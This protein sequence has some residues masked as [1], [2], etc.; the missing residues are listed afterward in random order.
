MKKWITPFLTLVVLLG[1]AACSNPS[2]LISRGLRISL[3]NPSGDFEPWSS[4]ASLVASYATE[5]P[6]VPVQEAQSQARRMSITFVQTPINDVL[7]SFAAFSGSESAVA[8]SASILAQSSSCTWTFAQRFHSS[9]S[10]SSL[11]RGATAER[12]AWSR[13]VA[14]LRSNLVDR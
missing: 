6:P 7:L 10:R 5:A 1:L 9:A 14:F 13:T 12:T 11:I 8:M 4:G 3:Q 2:E